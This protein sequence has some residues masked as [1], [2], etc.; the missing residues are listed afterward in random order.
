MT[1]VELPEDEAA[2]ITI[3]KQREIARWATGKGD[4][5]IRQFAQALGLDW[6]AI[7]RWRRKF[8][9]E[10]TVGK[11]VGSVEAPSPFASTSA[12]PIP[13]SADRETAEPQ[14][15]GEQTEMAKEDTRKHYDEEER[16]EWVAAFKKV[17]SPSAYKKKFPRGPHPSVVYG[18]IKKDAPPPEPGSR[19]TATGGRIYTEEFRRQ[20][21]DRARQSTA[22]AA[23]REFKVALSAVTNWMRRYPAAVPEPAPPAQASAPPWRQART[24]G[25]TPARIAK[26]DV[27]RLQAENALLRAQIAYLS[28]YGKLPG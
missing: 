22:S 18:W 3:D 17:G 24:Q 7:Y 8:A 2:P 4:E 25:M 1:E 12:S 9:D 16:K 5:E 26:A 14:Q 20:V 13:I 23:A 6:S 27:E 28:K 11:D 15:Q 21:A 10:P 19:T